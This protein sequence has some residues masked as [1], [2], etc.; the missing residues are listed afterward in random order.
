M[1]ARRFSIEPVGPFDLSRSIGFLESWP[2]TRRPAE[3]DDVLRFAYCAEH[4]WQ[5]VG[6]RV[7]QA[8]NRVEVAVVGPGSDEESVPAQVARILSL[9]VDSTGIDDIAAR[10]PIVARLVADAPGLRP[11]CFWS[12]W[13][14]AC[15]AVLTQRSSMHTASMQKQ[16]ITEKYG[17]A[18]T[19][20]G[21]ELRAFPA[22][23]V[24]LDVPSL[25]GANPVKTARIHDLATAALDDTLTAAALRAVS[26]DEALATLRELP[27]IGAFSAGLILMRGAGAPDVFTTSEPRLLAAVRAAYGLPHD[28]RDDSYALGAGFGEPVSAPVVDA[29]RF[30]RVCTGLLGVSTCEFD[31]GEF[32]PVWPSHRTRPAASSRRGACSAKFLVWSSSPRSRC[33]RARPSEAPPRWRLRRRRSPSSM[34]FR[35][36][37]AHSGSRPRPS[38][39]SP[40]LFSGGAHT[41]WSALPSA[42]G[43]AVRLR[44]ERLSDQCSAC[45]TIAG[46][47]RS[48][49]NA[50][51]FSTE[52][53]SEKQDQTSAMVNWPN[54]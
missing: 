23:G 53:S 33:A 48:Y 26:S 30:G 14:A 1:S 9:D 10:D 13:E 37:L 38:R 17:T 54:L 40:R 47:R 22:P 6:V 35:C 24:L 4:D 50:G 19:V 16:R 46:Q 31:G 25:P 27:G 5:P 43:R 42:K 52:K 28:A 21:R 44:S 36:A 51:S 18:V 49:C 20:D 11:V 34:A 45:W 8:G 3:G 12:P 2:A 41:T 39:A 15:W 32:G 7:A 29:N